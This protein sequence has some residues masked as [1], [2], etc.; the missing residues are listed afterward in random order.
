MELSGL[1]IEKLIEKKAKPFSVEDAKKIADFM[2]GMDFQNNHTGTVT[3]ALSHGYTG[4]RKMLQR[5]FKSTNV[6]LPRWKE[7]CTFEEAG[8]LNLKD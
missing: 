5:Y 8:P 1:S 2:P 3:N 7:N 4:D 6:W